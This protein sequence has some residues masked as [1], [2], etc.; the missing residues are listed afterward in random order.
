MK[1]GL[2]DETIERVR[3]VF[4]KFSGIEQ[5]ILYGSRALGTYR[6]SSDIDIT[7]KGEISFEELLSIE[8]E[9]D[10]LLLPYQF[11]ISRYDAI[12]EEKLLRHI[13]EHG[14]IFYKKQEER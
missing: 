6:N 8:G 11:D 1:Y 3:E 14:V 10:E 9:I 2:K 7:L 4:D 13:E 5:A 12:R